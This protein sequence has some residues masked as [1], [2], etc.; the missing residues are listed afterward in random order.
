MDNVLYKIPQPFVTNDSDFAV[1][2]DDADPFICPMD[3]LQQLIDDAPGSYELGFLSGIFQLRQQ[4]EFII[5][6]T[7]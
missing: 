7:Y 1:R 4:L 3:V 5:G 2:V 6:R